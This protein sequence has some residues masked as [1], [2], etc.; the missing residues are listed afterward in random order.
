MEE[1]NP[2]SKFKRVCVFCG[3]NPGH[4]KVF[5]DAALELGNELVC[6]F[7]LFLSFFRFLF[8]RIVQSQK[9]WYIFSKRLRF[10]DIVFIYRLCAELGMF[11]GYWNCTL[12]V[13]IWPQNEFFVK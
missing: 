10:D 9:L 2:R 11:L 8:F 13:G 7:L 3:S 4:R 6:L 1:G 12:V 5:S